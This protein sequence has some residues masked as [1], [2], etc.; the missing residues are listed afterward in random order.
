MGPRV[1]IA[2][3]IEGESVNRNHT[4]SRFEVTP[5]LKMSRL[6][7]TSTLAAFVGRSP[8]ERRGKMPL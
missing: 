2:E 7:P 8:P 5:R 6:G 4:Q 3:S 1:A